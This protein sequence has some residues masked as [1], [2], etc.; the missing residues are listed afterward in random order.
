MR[1]ILGG[2]QLIA[3]LT[4]GSVST[5]VTAVFRLSSSRPPTGLLDSIRVVHPVLS[6]R[7][8]FR[9]VLGGTRTRQTLALFGVCRCDL[10]LAAMCQVLVERRR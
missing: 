6:P 7:Y 3:A 10:D 1:P 4:R 5:V 9:R 8:G 2:R